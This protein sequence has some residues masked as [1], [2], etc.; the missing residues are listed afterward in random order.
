MKEATVHPWPGQRQQ[1]SGPRRNPVS[2][3]LAICIA[4]SAGACSGELLC[5]D[6]GCE[7]LLRYLPLRKHHPRGT[8]DLAILE[9]R[10]L[11]TV[12]ANDRA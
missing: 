5:G 6:V 9:K 11:R 2:G 10:C 3:W 8:R 7:G 1:D 4:L 12:L